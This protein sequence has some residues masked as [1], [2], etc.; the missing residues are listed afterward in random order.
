[1]LTACCENPKNAK[2]ALQ[3]QTQPIKATWCRP[4]SP[5]SLTQSS[6]PLLIVICRED[7][8][9]EDS[10]T[11]GRFPVYIVR[12][13]ME[14]GLSA[15]ISSYSIAGPGYA[16]RVCDDNIIKD[17]LRTAMDFVMA[18]KVH[19]ASV[20]GIRSDPATAVGVQT[21]RRGKSLPSTIFS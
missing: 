8:T 6:K 4:I 17:Q 15:P 20:F 10:N 19:V 18:L 5:A 7:Y 3:H 21:T 12:T 13:C 9:N 2:P 16:T 14:D 1:M 11:V